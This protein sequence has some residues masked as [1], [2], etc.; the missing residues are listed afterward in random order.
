MLNLLLAILP[1]LALAGC[2]V[3]RPVALPERTLIAPR[4][5]SHADFDRVL[6]RFV[7]DQGR[8]DYEALKNDARDL[9]RYYRLFSAHSPDSHSALFPTEHSKLAYWINAYNAGA[10]KTVLTYYPITSVEV[11]SS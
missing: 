10:I 1:L 3:I 8:V 5:F 9:E 11:T 4:M 6:H 2:T 7:D